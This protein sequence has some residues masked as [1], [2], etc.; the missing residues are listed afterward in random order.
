VTLG[1]TWR[2]NPASRIMV[3]HVREGYDRPLRQTPSGTLEDSSNARRMR[4]QAD[5]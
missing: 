3:N 1:V 2:L 4:V 5:F